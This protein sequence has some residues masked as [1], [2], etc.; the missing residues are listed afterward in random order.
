MSQLNYILAIKHN[1]FNEIIKMLSAGHLK[2]ATFS[3][4]PAPWNRAQ[5]FFLPILRTETAHKILYGYIMK[6]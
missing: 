5:Y 1:I 2:R 3:E 6:I 4:G